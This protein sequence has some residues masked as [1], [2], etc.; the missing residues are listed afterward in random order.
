MARASL[1]IFSSGESVNE[2][3]REFVSLLVMMFVSCVAVRL[4]KLF[5]LWWFNQQACHCFHPHCLNLVHLRS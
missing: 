1:V 4:F 2:R 3:Y 5:T